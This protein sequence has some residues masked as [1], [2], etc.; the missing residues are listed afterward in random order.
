MTRL[1]A[2]CIPMPGGVLITA[3]EREYEAL[4]L[5]TAGLTVE[6]IAEAMGVHR[7]TV[8]SYIYRWMERI[9]VQG[10]PM[11]TAWAIA[12]GVVEMAQI[13]ELWELYA[14]AVAVWQ[15]VRNYQT[16]LGTHGRNREAD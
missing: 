4:V 12:T 1:A 14:P 8:S 13:W 2:H 9:G 5:A 11:L 6:Q 10:R 16:Q 3:S 7:A 15:E